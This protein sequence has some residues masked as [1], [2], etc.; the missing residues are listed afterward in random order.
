VIAE[1]QFSDVDGILATGVLNVDTQDR[2][3]EIDIWKVD[4]SPLQRWP[5]EHEMAPVLYNPSLHRTASPPDE[6]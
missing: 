5:S 6:H 3:F 1:V 4:F 2:L